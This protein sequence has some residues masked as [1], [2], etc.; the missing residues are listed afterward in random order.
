MTVAGTDLAGALLRFFATGQA[1][2]G[3]FAPDAFLDL[4]VPQWRQQADGADTLV[5]LRR[6][7]HPSPGTVP[8]HRVDPT[9]TGFVVEWEERWTAD[10]QDW[11]CREMARAEV[12]GGAIS[13]LSVYCT[14]DWDA[15]TQ[16]RHAATVPLVRP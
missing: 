15:D 5:A 1:P 2:A 9:P 13:A 6:R 4:S 8:R 3:L 12:T 14:G 7:L 16:A 11:Y 10:G